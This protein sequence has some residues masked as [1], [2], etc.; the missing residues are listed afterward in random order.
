MTGFFLF[1]IILFITFAY[2]E[3]TVGNQSCWK[4][5]FF[6]HANDDVVSKNSERIKTAPGA[7]VIRSIACL[8]IIEV[9]ISVAS[10]EIDA[11][12]FFWYVVYMQ[13]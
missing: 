8:T 9:L 6:F 1:G 10:S 3:I 12:C 2:Y 7:D 5:H 11:L 13:Q 4:S